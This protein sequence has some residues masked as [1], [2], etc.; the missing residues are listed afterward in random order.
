MD[1]VNTEIM[2]HYFNLL[3]DVFEKNGL[4]NAPHQ[5]YNVDESG[6]PPKALN[7]VAKKGSKKVRVRLTGRKGQVTVVVCGN[8]TGQVIRPMII[9]D[10][11]KL[12]HAWMRGEVPQTSYGLSDKGW[13]TTEL[14]QS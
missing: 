12:W 4:I 9:Y 3:Q 14:F 10:A 5:I 13:I 11:K 6:I 1:A 2:Q 7:V 8:A